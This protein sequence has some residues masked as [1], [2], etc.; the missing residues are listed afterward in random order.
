MKPFPHLTPDP[1]RY[2]N[3]DRD[4]DPNL[5]ILQVSAEVAGNLTQR[6]IEVLQAPGES[7]HLDFVNRTTSYEEQVQSAGKAYL[8]WYML[9]QVPQHR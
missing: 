6:G 7:Q 8:D 2:I 1:N 3:P 5:K 9:R 4:P